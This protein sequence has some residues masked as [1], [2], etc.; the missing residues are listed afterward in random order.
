MRVVKILGALALLILFEV[1]AAAQT[2]TTATIVGVVTDP[3]AAA[4]GGATVELR[5]DATRQTF[6]QTTNASGQY[7]FPNVTPGLYRISV[8]MKGFRTTTIADFR[9]DVAKSYNADF[10]LELGELSQ[11]V[12]VE[13]AAKVELQTTDAAVGNTISVTQLP[14]MPALTRQVNEL[15]AFQ[16]GAT[17]TGEVTG[18][19]SDQSTFLLDGI[20]VTN[21]S[22]GGLNTYIF[23]PIDSIEEFR[24]GVAN[25][26]ASFGRGAGGQVSLVGR[27][28][29]SAYHG[30]GYWYH[31]NDELNA[32]SWENGHLKN[33]KTGATSTPRSELKDNRFGGNAGGPLPFL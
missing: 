5:N 1:S 22:I 3:Q 33:I 27:S 21:N 18:A 4:V 14:R 31:Q 8:T 9:V 30:T 24:V 12:Q 6:Q 10:K 16:P 17:P 7:A 23:L 2:A 13:A 26:N 29:T 20:D 32:N 19:R 11:V 15:L 28:G 25:T